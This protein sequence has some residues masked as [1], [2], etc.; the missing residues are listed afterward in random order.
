MRNAVREAVRLKHLLPQKGA[1][2]LRGIALAVSIG[3]ALQDLD[4]PPVVVVVNEVIPGVTPYQLDAVEA[5][6]SE[7]TLELLDHL[8]VPAHGAVEPLV[9]AVDD[10]DEVVQLLVARPRDGIDGLG[11]VHLTVADEAPDAAAGRVGKTPQVQVAEEPRLGHR[12]KRP[13]AHGDGGVLPEVR[14][15]PWVRVTGQALAAHL[16]AEVH[17]LLELQAALEVRTRIAAWSG[18]PLDVELVAHAP[19]GALAAEEVVHA[20]LPD[21]ADGGKGADVTAHTGS[22]PVAIADHDGRV[23]ADEVRDPALHGQV[24]GV[25]WLHDCGDGVAH[26]SRH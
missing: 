26:R 20:D 5:S 8:R 25:V 11:L 17:D 18:V 1:V 22:S 24:A 13:N 21:V 19:A 7:E 16:L 12:L 4:Q 6:A 10:E 14:H 9:V 15:Q 23:P 3:A 2:L